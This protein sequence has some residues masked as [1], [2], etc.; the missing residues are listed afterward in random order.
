MDTA[1]TLERVIAFFGSLLVG[2]TASWQLFREWHAHG[3]DAAVT[4]VL[5][6]LMILGCVFALL[7]SIT[8][9]G[10]FGAAAS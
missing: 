2:G 6:G 9:L 10:N 8:I 4:K 7:A 5:L 1:A 3:L